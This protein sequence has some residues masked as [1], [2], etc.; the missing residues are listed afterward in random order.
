MA[1]TCHEG[2]GWRPLRCRQSQR[3]LLGSGVVSSSRNQ[4]EG[5]SKTCSHL[6][7]A[8]A[9]HEY[10]SHAGAWPQARRMAA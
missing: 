2:T 7:G 9:P 3:L 6:P 10:R 1:S 8:R 5:V 4:A